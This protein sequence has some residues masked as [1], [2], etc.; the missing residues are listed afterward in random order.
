MKKIL[1]ATLLVMSTVVSA[2]PAHDMVMG[3]STQ[4]KE[5]IMGKLLRASGKSCSYVSKVKFIGKV[6]G[7]VAMWAVKCPFDSFLI[8]LLP[9][10][11][12]STRISSCGV[13]KTFTGVDCWKS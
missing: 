1:L 2:N 8:K 4:N 13:M 3:M 11:S 10:A 9:D 6:D 5:S 7:D 12:G